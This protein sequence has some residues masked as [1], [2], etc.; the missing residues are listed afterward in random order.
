[1]FKNL[2]ILF[3]LA[4]TGCASTPA[5]RFVW[6]P[7]PDEP[8]LEW[9]GVYYS[10][11]SFKL[12]A[13]GE[14]FRKFL[15]AADEIIMKAPFGIVSDGKGKVYVSDI[16]ERNV[17]IFDFNERK[18]RLLQ[19][20]STM[21][22]PTGLGID[23]TGNLYVAD[24]GKGVVRVFSP[25]GRPLFVFAEEE[26]T[27]PAYLAV[28]DEGGRIY[29][30]D[31]MEHFIAVFDLQGKF[32]FKFGERGNE[33]GQL[34]APQ[35]LALSPEG[36]LYVAD[37]FNARIQYFDRD[38]NFLGRF[39]ERGDQKN[40]F[41]NPKDLSFDSAGNLYVV[42]GR[43][44]D[45]MIYT[46]EGKLLL[47]VGDGKASTHPMAFAAPRGIFID[48]NDRIYV[49][50]NLNRRFSAWQYM[51][52]EYLAEHPYTEADKQNLLDYVEKTSAGKKE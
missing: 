47:V 18:T 16:H 28:D 29:V 15:G 1:M 39:G 52:K 20:S 38:G 40:Q 36:H 49:A 5:V 23:K 48:G 50:E 45:L 10:E 32:L 17:R 30:S 7:P 19:Q 2:I 25:Q 44:S 41:E 8:R 3:L 13:S 21:T 35:G 26:M 34:Y 12:A 33:D 31:G 4:L 42:D 37:M 46:P 6:P 27:K 22:T 14:A 24:S 9:V 43:R 11:N 51:S